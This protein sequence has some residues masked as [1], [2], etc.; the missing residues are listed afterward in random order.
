MKIIC[1]FFPRTHTSNIIIF[2]ASTVVIHEQV[3][4]I[5]TQFFREVIYILDTNPHGFE[6]QV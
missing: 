1:T 6:V 2:M 5:S 3:F 4:L